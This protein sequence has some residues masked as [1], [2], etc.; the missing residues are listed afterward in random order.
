M[1]TKCT[2]HFVNQCKQV[3]IE[4][5]GDFEPSNQTDD[6]S[7][8]IYMSLRFQVFRISIVRLAE[9]QLLI[10]AKLANLYIVLAKLALRI[11]HQCCISG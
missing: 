5:I 4:S 1:S 6:L 11:L 9:S 10:P 7:L 2:Y 8:R 3:Y